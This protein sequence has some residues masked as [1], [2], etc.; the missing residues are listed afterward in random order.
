MCRIYSYSIYFREYDSQR[1]VLFLVKKAGGTNT[2]YRIP[3]I[4]CLTSPG[5]TVTVGRHQVHAATGPVVII[6]L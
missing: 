6:W 5:Y 4:S 2:R 1:G 3:I